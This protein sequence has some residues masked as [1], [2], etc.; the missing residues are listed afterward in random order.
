MDLNISTI[1]RIEQ[2]LRAPENVDNPL[3]DDIRWVLNEYKQLHRREKKLVRI[4]DK[5]QNKLTD[6]T[7]EIKSLSQIAKQINMSLN[8]DYV[9]KGIV[10]YF[11]ETFGFESCF[12]A[13]VDDDLQQIN[14]TR[15]RVLAKHKKKQ[16]LLREFSESLDDPEGL[17]AQVV[18]SGKIL[19]N[20]DARTD[21]PNFAKYQQ[22]GE[23]FEVKSILFVPIT[24]AGQ[25]LGVFVFF[26]SIKQ[27]EIT[28]EHRKSMA[29]FADLV[30]VAVK[31][32]K[33]L[34]EKEKAFSDELQGF[35]DE[36]WSLNKA[37]QRF[38]PHEFLRLLG[39]D[40]IASINLGDHVQG[41]MSILFADIRSFTAMSETMSPKD[42]FMFLNSY[43]QTVGPLISKNSGFIDKYIGDAVMAIF[44]KE[45]QEAISAAMDI[46]QALDEYNIDRLK[47]WGNTINI[48]IGIHTGQLMLGTIGDEERM[49]GT[50]ISD[51][52]NLAS[53]VQDLTKEYGARIIISVDVFSRLNDPNMY[54]YRF[55]GYV[56]IKGKK[57]PVAVFEIFDADPPELK[58]I[59]MATKDDFE[60][61]MFHVN[62]ADPEKAL[63]IFLEINAKYPMDTV[64]SKLISNLEK[65]LHIEEDNSCVD[66]DD[67]QEGLLEELDYQEG[68]SDDTEDLEEVVD[69]EVLE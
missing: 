31:N 4:S 34:A 26:S 40:D 56:E 55:L 7:R 43:L 27:V 23:A 51:A 20:Q 32:S 57:K 37:Y 46:F 36:L 52:V 14:L 60:R 2:I 15:A 17:L 42:N 64:V 54:N 10:D 22:L 50:V 47:Y 9:F 1:D 59:K 53:R 11:S 62:S 44:P 61:A 19:F 66:P 65:Q 25:T 29:T 58:K 38:V 30:S 3:L 68:T 12:F 48:G 45:P 28:E 16:H 18:Q 6:A 63:Q 13:L 39:K 69:L 49:E 67:E 33:M 35:V 41:E 8:F 24:S 5:I 21:T